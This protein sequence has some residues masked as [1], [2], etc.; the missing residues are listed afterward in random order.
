[1]A[2]EAQLK[3][4][5]S[6]EWHISSDN[7]RYRIVKNMI[8]EQAKYMPYRFDDD[9]KTILS[10]GLYTV[11]AAKLVCETDNKRAKK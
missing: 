7:G 5:R 2:T 9:K 8:N 3:W 11:E 10:N 6:G 1:M 4:K